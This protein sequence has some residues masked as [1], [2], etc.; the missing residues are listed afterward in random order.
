MHAN[1][2]MSGGVGGA[3]WIWTVIGK[4]VFTISKKSKK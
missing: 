2:W 3:I 4:L 1:G